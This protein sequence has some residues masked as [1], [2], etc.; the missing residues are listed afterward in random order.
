MDERLDPLVMLKIYKYIFTYMNTLEKYY[1]SPIKKA[2]LS[3]VYFNSGSGFSNRVW[4]KYGKRL[5]SINSDELFLTLLKSRIPDVTVSYI[6][7]FKYL[8]ENSR[9]HEKDLLTLASSAMNMWKRN[10]FDLEHF[11]QGRNGHELRYISRGEFN[12][13]EEYNRKRK[14]EL[15]NHG[16]SK[17]SNR[18]TKRGGNVSKIDTPLWIRYNFELEKLLGTIRN[19]PDEEEV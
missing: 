12:A 16:P 7:S 6:D 15:E 5:L 4:K 1:L 17:R 8:Y 10:Y 18:K 13:L 11:Y 9:I 19:I 2:A 3:I 14:L